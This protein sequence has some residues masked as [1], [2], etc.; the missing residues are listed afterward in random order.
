MAKNKTT[1]TE[2]SVNDFL[3]GQSEE[4]LADCHTLIELMSAATKQPPKMWGPSIIG[5]GTFH[6]RYES[7]H[8]GDTCL[9]GFSP[10]K[11]A[12]TLYFVVGMF[13]EH[14][15]LFAE[16]GKCKMGKGCLYIKK[17]ADVDG[18]KLK[19]LITLAVKKAKA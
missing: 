16:L 19:K 6:Y 2:A 13:E 15:E 4:R 12:L 17:L 1:E 8:E 18:K 10:R 11:A 7:G 9:I 14:A 5:F 3:A